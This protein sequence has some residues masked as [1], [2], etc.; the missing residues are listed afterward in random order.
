MF[1]AHTQHNGVG[2][3]G[4]DHFLEVVDSLGSGFCVG[5]CHDQSGSVL[6][7]WVI[8]SRWVSST[9]PANNGNT[10]GNASG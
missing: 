2:L 5:F 1:V 3:T 7:R 10:S 8:S 6:S 9:I 4:Q